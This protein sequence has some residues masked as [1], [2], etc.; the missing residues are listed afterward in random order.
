MQS[1]GEV[2]QCGHCEG[3]GFCSGGEDSCKKCANAIGS[4]TYGGGEKVSC[5]TC[6]GKGSI[7]IGPDTIQI[8]S[9]RD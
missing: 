2:K 9:S 5:S 8:L 6:G 3:T 4:N 1:I 7:W